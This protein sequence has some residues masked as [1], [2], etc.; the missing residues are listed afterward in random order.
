V[1]TVADRPAGLTGR[2]S[3]VTEWAPAIAPHGDGPWREQEDPGRGAVIARVRDVTAAETAQHVARVRDWYEHAQLPE[4]AERAALL[5]RFADLV[6][7]AA[8]D[9]GELEA[10]CTGKLPADAA[11]TARGGAA[12]ARY[13]AGLID[14]ADPYTEQVAAETPGVYQVVDRVPVGIVA[15]ILPWNVPLSQTCARFTM[16]F[17]A[18]NASIVK[19]SELS[20]PPMLALEQLA[21]EAGLPPWALSILSGG[22]EVGQALAESPQ[23][24]AI[25]FT[26]GTDTGVRVAASAMGTL[27]R[28]ILELGGRTPFVVFADADLD[29]ALEA[30]LRA[31]FGFQGQN[32]VAGSRLLVEEPVAA[33]FLARFEQRTAA[34]RVGYQ[35]AEDT[36][37]GPVAS[38]GHR[39]RVSALVSDAVAA[40]AELRC[41][42]E[43]IEGDGYFYRP[44]VLRNVPP[45]AAAETDEIFGP[46]TVPETF[47]REDHVVGR[48]NDT[49]FG[50]ATTLW[51]R[52]RERVDRLR[53]RLRTGI[54]YVN[55]HGV[56]AR[57]APWGGFRM[58]GTGRLYGRDGLYAF[59][60]ARQTYAA[61]LLT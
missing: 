48:T 58:S 2:W 35:F 28:L 54:V 7:A 23:V 45:S 53:R 30:A 12:V 15:S 3:A 51:T 24:D 39:D 14:G 1:S 20:L 13:Y 46:V 50:L 49:R 38:A 33:D 43:R 60:E 44:T 56:V 55:S 21:I 31:A 47:S 6:E 16:G 11:A 32:C 40:G 5:R 9:L 17:A 25:C 29:A 27:K 10:L 59:T 52:D 34:L 42:G 57:N 19:G 41:G 8:P 61:D 22:P 18:G 26:G 4:L 36:E 37:I